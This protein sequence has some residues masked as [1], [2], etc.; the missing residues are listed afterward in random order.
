MQSE[1]PA[2]GPR[3]LFRSPVRLRHGSGRLRNKYPPNAR[4][5]RSAGGGF[6][7]HVPRLGTRGTAG[8]LL[9]P[10][11]SRKLGFRGRSFPY[12]EVVSPRPITHLHPNPR[13]RIRTCGGAVNSG[14][15]YQLGYSWKLRPVSPGPRGWAP[16]PNMPACVPGTSWDRLRRSGVEVLEEAVSFHAHEPLDSFR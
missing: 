5:S 2:A 12:V 14:V 6:R 7:Q 13:G 8:V 1:V 11:Y 9:N 10:C 4:S 16:R 3:A 15:P